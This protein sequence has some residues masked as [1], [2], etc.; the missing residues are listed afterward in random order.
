VVLGPGARVDHLAL[1]REGEDS[2]HVGSLQA[3]VGKAAHFASTGLTL[4]GGR[5]RREISVLLGEP[6]ARTTLDGLYLGTG[7]QHLD[8]RTF[9]DHAVQGCTSDENYRGVVGGHATAVFDGRVLV[10]SQAQKSSA[11]LTNKNLLLSDDATVNAK[12]MLEIFADD[13]KATHGEAVG[14]LDP[15]SLFYLRSRGIDE[16]EARAL[17]T[18]AF[19]REILA[20]VAV[21]SLAESLDRLVAAALSRLEEQA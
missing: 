20:R 17:L 4:S 9:V 19:A 8:H 15:D 13:V 11:N 6:G 14:R 7:E 18:L 1:V 3:S 12:P 21:P 2:F 5:V 16:S 10:R